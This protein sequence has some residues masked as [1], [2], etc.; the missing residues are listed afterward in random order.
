MHFFLS[1]YFLYIFNYHVVMKHK[2]IF[3]NLERKYNCKKATE[4]SW[5][6]FENFL[7]MAK[8]SLI[9]HMRKNLWSH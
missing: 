2:N 1:Y 6:E 8:L 3:F 9:I 7:A 4:S 5:N